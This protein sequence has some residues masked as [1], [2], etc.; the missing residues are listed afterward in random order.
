MPVPVRRKIELHLRPLAAK[1]ELLKKVN[2]D[3]AQRETVAVLR[4]QRSQR[5]MEHNNLLFEYK[6]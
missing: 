1:G 4:K 3:R 2:V 5:K 6:A